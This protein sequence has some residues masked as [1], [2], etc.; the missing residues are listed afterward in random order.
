MA[1]RVQADHF[2][3]VQQIRSDLASVRVLGFWRSAPQ[4]HAQAVEWLRDAVALLRHGGQG[5]S[6]SAGK[7]TST[8]SLQLHTA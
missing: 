7:V 2:H 5:K 4:A 1:G 3:S 6:K 8:V